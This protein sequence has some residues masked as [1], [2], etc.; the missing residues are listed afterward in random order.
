VPA[1]SPDGEPLTALAALIV[2]DS[3][4]DVGLVVDALENAGY[5]P[6]HWRRVDDAAGMKTAPLEQTWDLVLSCHRIP[7]FGFLNALAVLRASGLEV[8][9]IVVSG[10]LGKGTTTAAFR[11]GAADIVS[12]DR[13]DR[14]GPAVAGCLRH[15]GEERQGWETAEDEV[16][17]SQE[18][19][20]ALVETLTDPS[21]LLSP[22]RDAEGEVVEFV[23]EYA[24]DAACEASVLAREE[25]VGSRMLGRLAQLAPA[26]LFDAYATVIESSQP[27][28]LEGFTDSWSAVAD[29]RFFDVWVLKAGELLVLTW[30]EVTE[31]DRTEEERDRLAAIEVPWRRRSAHSMLGWD[32]RSRRWLS[33][34]SRRWRPILMGLCASVIVPPRSFSVVGRATYSGWPWGR[35]VSLTRTGRSR[36]RSSVGCSR[37]VVGAACWRFRTPTARRFA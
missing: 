34:V 24:N 5:Q 13:F 17:D 3:S 2:E 18:R 33:W 6:L 20:Q 25:L 16:R 27:L 10:M 32:R 21:V 12:N 30:R 14:L 4:Y 29:R 7:A 11:A 23:Y 8:P 19:F 22:L 26:G 28:T 31:R 1:A 9:L 36:G 15:K 37:W 35:C